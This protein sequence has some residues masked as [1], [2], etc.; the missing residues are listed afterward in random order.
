MCEKICPNPAADSPCEGCEGCKFP[1]DYDHEKVLTDNGWHRY[2]SQ[3]SWVHPNIFEYLDKY[4]K[5]YWCP[6]GDYTNM[7]Y[8]TEEAISMNDKITKP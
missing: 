3:T 6:G 8:T 4:S 1:D 5:G 7:Q 2:Y